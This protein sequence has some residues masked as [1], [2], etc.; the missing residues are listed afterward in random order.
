MMYHDVSHVL[1]KV[2][3]LLHVQREEH[4]LRHGI[5]AVRGLA[6]LTHQVNGYINGYING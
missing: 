6:H 5:P 3:A 2:D 4:H 1:V